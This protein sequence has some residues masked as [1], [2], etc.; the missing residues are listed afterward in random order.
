MMYLPSLK[1][2]RTLWLCLLMVMLMALNACSRSTLLADKNLIEYGQDEQNPQDRL[3][4]INQKAAEIDALFTEAEIAI[5]QSD[6]VAA[7]LAYEKILTLDN[8][9]L[10]AKDGLR[11]IALYQRHEQLFADAQLLA[12]G[13][14]TEQT[15]AMEKLSVIL[16]EN[17]NHEAASKLYQQLQEAENARRLDALKTKLAYTE[18]VSLEFR[19]TE[20][21]VIIEALAKGTG[22]NF[23]LDG[24]VSSELR[25]SLFVRNVPLEQALDV[26]VQ[27]NNLRKKVLSEDTVLLYPDTVAKIRQYQDLI[28]RSFYLEYADP[29][30]VAGLLRSMLGINQVETDQRL[31]MVMI[32]DIPEVMAL[33]EK[34]IASQDRPEPE[35]MLEM[36]I[37]EVSRNVSQDIGVRWPSQLSVLSGQDTLT[38]EQLRNTDSG[39]IGVSPNPALIFDGQDAQI[40]LLANPR[41]RVKNRETAKILIGD[42]LPIITSNVSSTG[43]ISENVQYIDVGLKLD[44]IPEINLGGDV[45]IALN[46]DVSSVGN[47]VTTN[48]GSVV[49]QIGTRSTSTQLRLKDG[50]TQVLAGLISDSDRKSI[51]KVPGVGD[52]PILG[53]LFSTHS[54]EV[55]KTELVLSITPRIIRP[56]TP[57]PAGLSQYWVGSELQTGRSSTQPRSR[58]EISKLFTPGVPPEA[59]RSQ[60]TETPPPEPPEGLN[61]N[62][63]PGLSSE[64]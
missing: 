1:H 26:L 2:S 20:L 4:E 30:S 18:P 59:S 23:T 29:E 14:L 47:S 45:N 49:F 32:K 61:I 56:T 52:L 16:Q 64:F 54:D 10:T 36:E 19:D 33:A 24:D 3:T 37:I 15:S 8:E 39:T 27:S 7:T 40:N 46:L 57:L 11:R 43:V 62:L 44:A 55:I 17:P 42:R 51:S 58:E 41:I 50:E 38:L 48:S 13:S 12:K 6:T 5:V 35:V 21:K 28:I 53:R 63:P 34:L 22:V 9:N 60:Q 31:P 25:S